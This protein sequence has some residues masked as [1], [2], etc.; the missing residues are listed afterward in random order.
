MNNC[1]EKKKIRKKYKIHCVLNQ[2]NP[3]LKVF[4]QFSSNL[5]D[6]NLFI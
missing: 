5:Y 6:I 2:F 4:Q 1:E 3:Y